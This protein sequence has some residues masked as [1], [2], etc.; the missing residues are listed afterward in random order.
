MRHSTVL[1]SR[2]NRLASLS[3]LKTAGRDP[4]VDVFNTAGAGI[5]LPFSAEEAAQQQ[6]TGPF[7]GSATDA[8]ANVV[9]REGYPAIFPNVNRPLQANI[10][11]AFVADDAIIGGGRTFFVHG[12]AAYRTLGKPH[13]SEYCFWLG[14]RI[15][16][17][18]GLRKFQP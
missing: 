18:T 16:E 12:C 11:Q 3:S 7:G 10:Q 5:T 17:H 6:R 4:A 9:P 1:C 14:P 13:V 8:C 2:A 15:D